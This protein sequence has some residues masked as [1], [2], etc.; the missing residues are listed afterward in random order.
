MEKQKSTEHLKTERLVETSTSPQIASQF[1]KQLLTFAKKIQSFPNEKRLKQWTKIRL[2]LL[3]LFKKKNPSKLQELTK[4]LNDHLSQLEKQ[5]SKPPINPETKKLLSSLNQSRTKVL[6]RYKALRILH[7]NY[8]ITQ[9]L[10]SVLREIAFTK[11][12]YSE[13]PIKAISTLSLKDKAILAPKLRALEIRYQHLSDVIAGKTCNQIIKMSSFLTPYI[14]NLHIAVMEVSDIIERGKNQATKNKKQTEKMEKLEPELIQKEKREATQ[15]KKLKGAISR[16]TRIN[17]EQSKL[18][19]KQITKHKQAYDS[20]ARAYANFDAPILKD[21]VHAKIMQLKKKYIEV[22]NFE[23]RLKY[24]IKAVQFVAKHKTHLSIKKIRYGFV[25]TINPQAKDKSQAQKLLTQFCTTL[26]QGRYFTSIPLKLLKHYQKHLQG[27][28]KQYFQAGAAIAAGKDL[29]AIESLRKFIELNKDKKGNNIYQKA[30]IQLNRLLKK[31]QTD[32]GTIFALNTAQTVNIFGEKPNHK[33][34]ESTKQLKAYIEKNKEWYKKNLGNFFL[35]IEATFLKQ[36]PTK[37]QQLKKQFQNRVIQ[38]KNVKIKIFQDPKLNKTQKQLR[39]LYEILMQQPSYNRDDAMMSSALNR[40]K[41]ANC[42]GQTKLTVSLIQKVLPGVTVKVQNFN[43]H[44][45]PIVKLGSQWY[46]IYGD[47]ISKI[48]QKYLEGTELFDPNEFVSIYLYKKYKS[49]FHQLKYKAPPGSKGN[50]DLNT[51]TNLV[52]RSRNKL[53]SFSDGSIPR[54][55][56]FRRSG[57][58][59]GTAS[60]SVAR[61]AQY[62]RGPSGNANNSHEDRRWKEQERKEKA[63]KQWVGKRILPKLRQKLS[64]SHAIDG[65]T[66]SSS[67]FKL[68]K[69][70]NQ[71]NISDSWDSLKK[72]SVEMS[73]SIPSI[74][75]IKLKTPQYFIKSKQSWTTIKNLKRNLNKALLYYQ[76]AKIFKSN[77]YRQ[78]N[79]SSKRSKLKKYLEKKGALLTIIYSYMRGHPI[80]S[81]AIG[82]NPKQPNQQTTQPT[83]ESTLIKTGQKTAYLYFTEGNNGMTQLNGYIMGYQSQLHAIQ[84]SSSSN[85]E[86]QQKYRSL[87]LQMENTR[88]MFL[89]GSPKMKAAFS[90]LTNKQVFQEGKNKLSQLKLLK[91][92]NRRI[93]CVASVTQSDNIFL[94]SWWQPFSKIYQQLVSKV[95][96][97]QIRV[98][99]KLPASRPT[100]RPIEKQKLTRYQKIKEYL[101]NVPTYLELLGG[102]HLAALPGTMKDEIIKNPKLKKTLLRM[103]PHQILARYGLETQGPFRSISSF[104]QSSMSHGGSRFKMQ[105]KNRREAVS[106]IPQARAIF[107]RNLQN[108]KNTN[109]EIT[110]ITFSDSF[111]RFDPF[112]NKAKKLHL[113]DCMLSSSADLGKFANVEE[114]TLRQVLTLE[115]GSLKRLTNLTPLFHLSKLKKLNIEIHGYSISEKTEIKIQLEKLKARGVKIN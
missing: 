40:Q 85:S 57:F 115:S 32:R 23:S 29:E 70:I 51:N 77:D 14:K 109:I 55:A 93:T 42:E 22:L 101:D 10:G 56:P 41:G 92:N 103:S 90:R 100:S 13:D 91:P 43:D 71:I 54:Y 78:I 37:L 61:Y 112:L 62:Q 1:K 46:L 3:Q 111:F 44:V 52:M 25:I 24:E 72:K 50:S 73:F 60:S 74:G 106:K 96:T 110:N 113:Y 89:N 81:H 58:R 38:L 94:K 49:K 98:V 105:E 30:L 95:T 36:S 87:L 53:R 26:S 102:R 65:L 84:R 7:K 45:Q 20:V 18:F 59:I 86:K 21:K 69:K 88:Q 5:S 82:K 107:E 80:Y 6:E 8:Q 17:L 16:R 31:V 114:L 108:L 47:S 28:V 76:L 99:Q 4:S 39:V 33:N 75:I 2:F 79:P 12:R 48:D 27:S 15:L 19:I 104:Y 66:I 64:T 11:N 63:A 83:I 68:L 67:G 97:N 34:T 9:L 35:E